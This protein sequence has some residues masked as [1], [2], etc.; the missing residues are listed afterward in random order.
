MTRK[1]AGCIL[2]GVAVL[3]AVRGVGGECTWNGSVSTEWTTAGNWTGGLPGTGDDVVVPSG[4]SFAPAI[5]AGTNP[6]SGAYASFTVAKG[7]TVT[8]R[9]E[10]AA[11]NEPSGGTVAKPHGIGVT[12]FATNAMIDGTLSAVG[13]GFP[14][15]K[16]PGLLRTGGC[17]HGG[18]GTFGYP[19][20]QIPFHRAASYGS[21]SEPTALGSGGHGGLDRSGGGAIR[22]AVEETLAVNGTID[23]TA[24]QVARSGSGGSIWLSATTF[25]GTGTIRA[26]GGNSAHGSSG[27]GGR[28]AI[29]YNHSTFS[30]LVSVAGGSGTLLGQP[31]SLWEPKRFEGMQGSPGSFLTVLATNNFQYFFP[32]AATTNFWNL[33][34]SNAWFEAHGGAM[35]IGDLRLHN[36]HFGFDRA[37]DSLPWVQAMDVLEIANS[38]RLVGASVPT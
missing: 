4:T 36:G 18:K 7:A 31:G 12:I 38:I 35:R 33:T 25:A 3:A 17:T 29:V 23:A 30:G 5:P 13:K 1:I 11:V 6:V 24:A 14:V 22:L 27:G 20:W 32:S 34:V 21:V 26:D 28:V 8:C 2:L 15:G 9:G 37:C 19:L 10:P 16:A